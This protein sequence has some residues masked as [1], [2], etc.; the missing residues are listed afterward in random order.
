MAG[1]NCTVGAEYGVGADDDGRGDGVAETPTVPTKVPALRLSPTLVLRPPRMLCCPPTLSPG[2][3]DT[4]GAPPP[5]LLP[6]LPL[7]FVL[8]LLP[9]GVEDT[10]PL[11]V[12]CGAA[13]CRS[14]ARSMV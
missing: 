11:K 12:D 10:K 3:G 14:A 1:G 5:P 2:A 8:L 13:F 4:S 9:K 7:L 6:P